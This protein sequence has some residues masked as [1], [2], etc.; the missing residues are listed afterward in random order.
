M[1]CSLKNRTIRY[2]INWI[3][4]I[5]NYDTFHLKRKKTFVWIFISFL[6]NLAQCQHTSVYAMSVL[7]VLSLASFFGGLFFLHDKNKNTSTAFRKSVVLYQSFHMRVFPTGMVKSGKKLKKKNHHIY[8]SSE[9]LSTH[10]PHKK[11]KI[12]SL[13]KCLKVVLAKNFSA[14]PCIIVYLYS[15]SSLTHAYLQNWKFGFILFIIFFMHACKCFLFW[16]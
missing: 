6:C 15:N 11:W 4:I 5:F 8:G 2:L 13:A 7:I 12:W 10:P 16:T 9:K 1:K 14:S 3:W